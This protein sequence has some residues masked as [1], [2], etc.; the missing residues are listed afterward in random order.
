MRWLLAVADALSVSLA[1][2]PLSPYLAALAPAPRPVAIPPPPC[3]RAFCADCEEWRELDS[4]WRCAT[5]GSAAVSVFRVRK[6]E[7]RA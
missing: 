6:E 2:V 4:R 5:C 3:P 7:S 1:G